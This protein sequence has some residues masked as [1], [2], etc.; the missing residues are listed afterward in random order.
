MRRLI[1]ESNL[2][3]QDNPAPSPLALLAAT[4]SKIGGAGGD[5][6][7]GSPQE[8][9]PVNPGQD[10]NLVIVPS[11]TPP[12][13]HTPT[14]Q[15][16]PG[17]PTPGPA[18]PQQSIRL[19]NGGAT[20]IQQADGTLVQTSPQAAPPQQQQPQLITLQQLQQLQQ[21]SQQQFMPIVQQQVTTTIN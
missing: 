4:C 7:G 5:G 17:T 3:L 12:P 19:I 20:F 2:F 13:S 1:C 10:S 14:Q 11:G 6:G 18:T 16:E 15:Q 21:Q 8:P 9:Q